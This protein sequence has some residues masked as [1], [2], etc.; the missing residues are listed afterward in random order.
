MKKITLITLLFLAFSFQSHANNLIVG[1]PVISGNTLTFTIKWDNSWYVTT[2][3]SN[4]D[5]VWIFVKRQTCISGASSPWIHAQLAASGQSVTGTVLQV[6][7]VSDNAGVFVRRI[8]AGIGNITQETIIL[9]LDAPVGA[10][11]IGVYG[12]EMVNVP[13]GNFFIGD[14]NYNNYQVFGDANNQP[15]QIT[16][17]TTSLTNAQYGNQQQLGSSVTLPSTYPFGY[18][19]FLLYEI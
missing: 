4:W 9:T 18:N 16:S 7:T 1:T 6:D 10:D 5:A 8:S 14:G 13:T 19:S 11:N 12:M 3:P 2:G 15:L 17:S